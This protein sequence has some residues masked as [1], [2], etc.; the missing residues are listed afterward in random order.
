MDGNRDDRV[1][2]VY[3]RTATA[4]RDDEDTQNKEEGDSPAFNQEE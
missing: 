3:L 1:R 4:A 2:R